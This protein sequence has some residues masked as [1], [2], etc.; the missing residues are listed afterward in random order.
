MSVPHIIM[1]TEDGWISVVGPFDS[2]DRAV[3]YRQEAE[4]RFQAQ[5]DCS[6]G[7]SEYLW[8]PNTLILPCYD[9]DERLRHLNTG[10][11]APEACDWCGDRPD[12]SISIRL[13]GDVDLTFCYEQCAW[14][15]M[16]RF[17]EYKET[18]RG[19]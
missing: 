10:A 5:R 17:A 18:E 13:A 14:K 7:A 15:W 2:R 1:Y 19:G 16:D 9:P 8:P 12:P 3:S 11:T 6:A 4:R